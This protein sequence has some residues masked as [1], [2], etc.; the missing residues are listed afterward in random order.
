MHIHI[1]CIIIVE[2]LNIRIWQLNNNLLSSGIFYHLSS[3]QA[4][5]NTTLSVNSAGV[6]NYNIIIVSLFRTTGYI[7]IILV[8]VTN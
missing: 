8:S 7:S 3:S 1:I 2:Y 5:Y 4:P 6:T